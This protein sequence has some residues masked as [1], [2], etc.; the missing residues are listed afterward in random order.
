MDTLSGLTILAT[1]GKANADAKAV[2]TGAALLAGVTINSATA[3]S[4]GHTFAV[5]QNAKVLASDTGAIRIHA[6]GYS[7]ATSS[8]LGTAIGIAGVGS[9]HATTLNN[10]GTEARIGAGVQIGIPFQGDFSGFPVGSVEVSA[11][12]AGTGLVNVSGASGGIVTVPDIH[13][14]LD[15]T[16]FAHAYIQ[17]NAGLFANGSVKVNASNYAEGDGTLSGKTISA[18]DFGSMEL[19]HDVKQTAEAIVSGGVQIG[20]GDLSVTAKGG[21]PALKPAGYDGI[22]T[23]QGNGFSVGIIGH[24]NG[25]ATANLT[26]TVRASILN[27]T[28]GNGTRIFTSNST[29]VSAD[30][31]AASAKAVTDDSGGGAIELTTTTADAF[32]IATTEA[33]IGYTDQDHGADTLNIGTVSDVSVHASANL[34]ADATSNDNGGGL[35]SFNS[36]DAQAR[37][38]Y[39]TLAGFGQ[40]VGVFANNVNVGASTTHHEITHI[41]NQSHGGI[42]GSTAGDTNSGSFASPGSTSG[43]VVGTDT[44]VWAT[45]A[46][47][48]QAAIVNS[49]LEAYSVS[50][51]QDGAGI[52]SATATAIG[53]DQVRITLSSGSDIRGDDGVVINAAVTN[54]LVRTD[55][56]GKADISVHANSFSNNYANITITVD[57][58]AGAKVEAGRH[59]NTGA[60]ALEVDNS[61]NVIRQAFAN[62][63]GPGITATDHYNGRDRTDL[64][65]KHDDRSGDHSKATINWN[66]DVTLERVAPEKQLVIDASGVV[67]EADGISVDGFPFS[68]FIPPDIFGVVSAIGHQTGPIIHVGDITSNEVNT[69]EFRSTKNN[70]IIFPDGS[71][72][73]EAPNENIRNVITGDQGT[74]LIGEGA[75]V[76]SIVNNS[77][78]TL[79]INNIETIPQ[80]TDTL[81][82]VRVDRRSGCRRVQVR[83]PAFLRR[84]NSTP[85]PSPPVCKFRTTRSLPAAT[86]CSTA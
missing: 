70:I 83:H 86:S 80:S 12:S 45:G 13:G 74:W 21:D 35:A 4:T 56:R 42:A 23:A 53:D 29:V 65:G 68:F 51:A 1:T 73:A 72:P 2:A 52:T 32:V 27:G 63:D 62:T 31:L 20:A 55:A 28:M 18:I 47:N 61:L 69:A 39:S 76:I 30:T 8:A 17:D 60:V 14:T 36:S 6:E 64:P 66:A 82:R 11:T 48:L 46:L 67:T 49:S 38:S 77:Q 78:S 44:Q 22:S 79:E 19:D 81:S 25:E 33:I 43:I 7:D 85:P 10:H 54:Y 84:R 41:D 3:N 50:N 9:T 37:T 5:L 58:Q 40:G 24:S 15:V 75:G 26:S 71:N 34:S 59:T 16:P 57:A